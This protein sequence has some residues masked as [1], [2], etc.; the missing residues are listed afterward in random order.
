[1]PESNNENQ[2]DNLS[3][4]DAILKKYSDLLIELE[5]LRSENKT[6]KQSLSS[7]K[8]VLTDKERTLEPSFLPDTVIAEMKQDL[9]QIK[10]AVNTMSRSPKENSPKRKR[11]PSKKS[12]WQKFK[13]TIGIKPHRQ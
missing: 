13:S 8:L 2:N 3:A 10:L 6:L 4:F 9:S 5:Q 7:S 1:M 11:K 12:K